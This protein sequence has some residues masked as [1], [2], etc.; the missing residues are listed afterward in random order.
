MGW[1]GCWAGTG[2]R[3]NSCHTSIKEAVKQIV[4]LTLNRVVDIIKSQFGWLASAWM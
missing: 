4:V 2:T 1:L 3:A